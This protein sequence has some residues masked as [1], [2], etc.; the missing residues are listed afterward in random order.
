MLQPRLVQFSGSIIWLLVDMLLIFV[1]GILK[2]AI[3]GGGD[4]C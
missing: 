1:G 4:F 2:T 3:S